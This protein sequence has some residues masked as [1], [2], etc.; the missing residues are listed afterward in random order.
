[1]KTS[2]YKGL[3]NF[4]EA[5]HKGTQDEKKRMASREFE[6]CLD[7]SSDSNLC[8]P[9]GAGAAESKKARLVFDACYSAVVGRSFV[10]SVV[11]D[12]R[13]YVWLF[14]ESTHEY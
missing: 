3:R 1:M 12:L 2:F 9:E 5:F 8:D 4:I 7:E 6:M 11:V 10:R 14:R 13:S